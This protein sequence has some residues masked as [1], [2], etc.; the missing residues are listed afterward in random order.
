M[1]MNTFNDGQITKLH[2]HYYAGVGQNSGGPVRIAELCAFVLWLTLSFLIAQYTIC[3][4]G[5]SATCDTGGI[6]SGSN[7]LVPN[8]A[9]VSSRVELAYLNV[10]SS[11]QPGG[12]RI[13]DALVWFHI[14]CACLTGGA[15]RGQINSLCK[16][17]LV[18]RFRMGWWEGERLLSRSNRSVCQIEREGEGAALDLCSFVIV[19]SR[20]RT[21]CTPARRRGQSCSAARRKP[22][23]VQR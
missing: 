20:C 8:G 19:Q 16:W 7:M 1:I 4:T 21:L 5:V 14:T 17:R 13:F 12:F 10:H 11:P 15:N 9:A 2:L 23:Q 22:R 6:F 3:E 18:C